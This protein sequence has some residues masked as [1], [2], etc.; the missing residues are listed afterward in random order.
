MQLCLL[1]MAITLQYLLEKLFF[2][3]LSVY[4]VWHEKT[5]RTYY[6]IILYGQILKTSKQKKKKNANT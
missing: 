1:T 2:I 4:K 3:L 6:L 5:I